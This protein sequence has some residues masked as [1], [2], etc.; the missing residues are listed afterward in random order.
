[1]RDR[2]IRAERER[3]KNKN[4]VYNIIKKHPSSTETELINLASPMAK[5]TVRSCLKELVEEGKKTVESLKRDDRVSDLER[6]YVIERKASN[7][8]IYTIFGSPM[9]PLENQSYLLNQH[10]DME[11][12]LNLLNSEDYRNSSLAQ[13]R[14]FVVSF[15]LD[16]I[17]STLWDLVINDIENFSK[18][19]FTKEIRECKERIKRIFD[20]VKNDPEADAIL[21]HMRAALVRI[22]REYENCELQR[23]DFSNLTRL[24]D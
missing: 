24:K 16:P 4:K 6:R 7:R 11:Y 18:N 3:W 21:P 1:M 2:G 20:L 9:S 22:P 15:V 10:K 14:K 23:L 5:E 19:R 13:R 17:C 12:F 8:K